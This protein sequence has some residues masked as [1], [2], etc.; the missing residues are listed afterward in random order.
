ME[1][2]LVLSVIL[3]I[4][5]L[6]FLILKLKIQPFLALLVS[7]MAAGLIAGMSPG[8]VIASIQQGMAS[9]L[10]FVATVVG[11]GALFGAVLEHS[12]GAQSLATYLLKKFGDKKAPQA[13]VITGFI[14]AIPVFF[15]VAFVILVPIIYALQAKTGKSLLLF[16]L[17]L[18]AGLAITH[19]FIPPTPG[20]VAVA[21][22]LGA[23]LGWV[24]AFGFLTGIPVALVAGIWFSKRIASKL[25]IGIPSYIEHKE[26][27]ET[28]LPPFFLILS[29]ITVPIVLIVF[30]TL[31]SSPLADPWGIP[32]DIVEITSFLGHPFTAL[33]LANGL[34]WYFLGIKRKMS[35]EQL[36]EVSSRSLGPAG[37]IIL[38]TGA[39]GV[40]KQV[41]VDTGVG[42]LLAESMTSLGIPALIFAFCSA[43]I[44]RI[45]QG[46]A[47][48][49]MITAAG[50]TASLL[51]S[52]HGDMERALMVIAIASGATTLS[53]VN[54]SGFWLVNRYLGLTEKQTFQAWSALTTIIALVGF[55]M[56][57]LFF[58]FLPV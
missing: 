9:T 13:M 36:L 43:A 6:L 55:A 11:L 32:S 30:N 7:S 56:V 29:I 20:P 45:L 10:G 4:I 35:K 54:D 53:H 42:K 50:L 28:Q 33:T 22:I 51:E 57:A 37:I 19:S 47:T 27:D 8:A 46:S 18:L 58:L 44:V 21:E 2:H 12:G 48:V 39:G 1:I 40:F 49:A 34:A 15:D 5:L 14:V 23:P 41:L 38:L 16:A 3:S 52:S 31:I 25:H 26:S 24:I 17:P